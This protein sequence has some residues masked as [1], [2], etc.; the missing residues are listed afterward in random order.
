MTLRPIT[1]C[2]WVIPGKLLAGEYPRNEDEVSSRTKVCALLDFGINQF[3]DLTEENEG[4][5]A[6]SGL[7]GEASHQ[8]FPIRDVS[9]P[10]STGITMPA[11]DAIDLNISQGKM[12]YVHCWGGVGRTGVIVGCWLARDGLGGTAALH[13]LRE[14]WKQCPKSA[15]RITPETREQEKYLLNWEAGQRSLKKCAMKA[16]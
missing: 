1:N 8:R 2:F 5:L 10:N 7:I 11:L 14:L 9:L 15:Y 16:A 12:V 13:R 4:L 6:Y 3:I